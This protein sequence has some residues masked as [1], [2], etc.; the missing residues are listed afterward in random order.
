MRQN[1][2]GRRLLAALP[3]CTA[4]LSVLAAV[5]GGSV[6]LL[7][8]AA[9]WGLPRPAALALLAAVLTALFAALAWALGSG[10]NDRAH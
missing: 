4:G 8:A 10:G 5:C 2:K 3:F 9:A 1:R 7:R 6:G